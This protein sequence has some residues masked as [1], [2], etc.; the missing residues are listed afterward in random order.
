MHGLVIFAV[1]LR[2]VVTVRFD[3]NATT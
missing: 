1:V 2:V 3:Q